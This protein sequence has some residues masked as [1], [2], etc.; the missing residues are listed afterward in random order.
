MASRKSLLLEHTF[1][2]CKIQ[3]RFKNSINLARIK[4]VTPVLAQLSGTLKHIVFEL[5]V[6]LNDGE[7]GEELTVLMQRPNNEISSLLLLNQMSL[8]SE[9][10]KFMFAHGKGFILKTDLSF[11]RYC[12]DSRRLKV[13]LT[14]KI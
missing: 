14:Q 12:G 13:Y 10:G 5:S 1:L 8:R 2:N 3:L 9:E 6:G 11:L 7:V 4:A